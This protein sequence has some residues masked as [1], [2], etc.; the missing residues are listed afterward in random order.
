MITYIVSAYDRPAHLHCCL[1]SLAI[2]QGEKQIIVASNATEPAMRQVIR[3]AAL[4][5]CY[6]GVPRIQFV[7]TAALGATECYSGIEAVMEKG[8]VRGEWLCFPS[9]DSYYVPPFA[10]IMLDAAHAN[11]WDL[12]YPEAIIYDGRCIYG[13]YA[14]FPIDPWPCSIDKTCFML[15]R[16]KFPATG[17][18]GKVPGGAS[19]SDG[20]L[21]QQLVQ[22]GISHGKAPGVLVVHN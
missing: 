15:K 11:A 4:E 12:V 19:A 17:F 8:I 2:Q 14:V 1:S 9:D 22:G 13:K 5:V 21:V 6:H 3:E 20:L 7:D 10:Q 18:P 16:D